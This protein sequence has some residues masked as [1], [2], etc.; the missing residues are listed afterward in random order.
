MVFAEDGGVVY[1]LGWKLKEKNPCPCPGTGCRFFFVRNQTLY[2]KTLANMVID[3]D[4]DKNKNKT[5]TMLLLIPLGRF[6]PA[7]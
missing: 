3:N 7:N 4:G 2:R 1:R 5:I 6:P